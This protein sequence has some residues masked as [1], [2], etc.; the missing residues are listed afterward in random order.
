[1]E[2]RF[3]KAVGFLLENANPSTK[4][5]I[6]KELFHTITQE[7]EQD[8]RKQI[9]TEPIYQKIA[10]CQKENG[11]LGNGFHG[12]NRDAGP[13]ENQEVGIKYL[14]EKA[15]G[16]EDPVLKHAMDAFVTIP[17]DDPCYR[18]KGKYYD[19]FRYAANGQNLIRCACIAR[20]GYD[21]EIN[22]LP[23]IGLSLESFRRVLEV[24][25]ILEV[26]RQRKGRPSRSN[27][28]G[29]I[30][31]F[32]DYE[33]WP[34]R[35]HLDILAHTASWKNEETVRTLAASVEKMMRHDD[36][37]LIGRAA[38]SWVGYPLGTLG[39]FPSQGLTVK[40]TQ[41]LPCSESPDGNKQAA[42]YHLEYMEWFARCGI[43]P[44]VP[45]LKSAAEDIRDSFDENGIC[46]IPFLEDTLRGISTYGGQQLETDWKTETKQLCDVTFRAL[47]ILY[48]SNM[49]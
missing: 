42:V 23:Q 34:C 39:C 2:I 32:N 33:K 37:T 21:D 8:Y 35:Y 26:T 28:S 47:L 9:T 29:M 38:D 16:K 27:P 4:L 25:S 30:Y 20:A 10:A 40:E 22:I 45:V 7:E 19:E 17:L 15:V 48:Y 12:P 11:W 6:K 43:V 41:L 13:Y 5:R 49:L 36:P 31:V 3:Q 14:A 44:Y 1:M 24:D 46:R 18:T